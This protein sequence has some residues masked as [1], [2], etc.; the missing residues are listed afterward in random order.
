MLPKVADDPGFDYNAAM[1]TYDSGERSSQTHRSRT[2]TTA[3]VLLA[4]ILALTACGGAAGTAE[5]PAATDQAPSAAAPTGLADTAVAPTEIILPADVSPTTAPK[6]TAILVPTAEP[7]ADMQGIVLPDGLCANP[8]FPVV[9]GAIYTYQTDAPDFGPTTYSLTFANVTSNSFD[10]ILGDNETDIV[11]YTWQCLEDGL[12]SPNVQLN[13]PG[14]DMTIETV[15][16][17]GITFPTPEN[18]E[19]GHTWTTRSVV[20]STVADMGAGAMQTQQT[21]ELINEIVAIEPVTTPYGSFENAVKVQSTGMMEMIT[22]MGDITLPAMSIDM[23]SNAW[24]VENVGRVRSE[25]LS[26]LFGTGELNPS[27]TELISID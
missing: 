5:S 24:Y 8:Y 17:S 15:E 21:T 25:D 13:A 27:I 23:S 22:T 20:N 10:M 4:L 14:L 7:T 6:P 3:L 1:N 26:D 19:V 9:D 2:V 16:A 12:L 11:T 18:I